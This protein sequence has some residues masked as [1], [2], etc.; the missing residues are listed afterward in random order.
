MN[1]SVLEHL[2]ADSWGWETEG[3]LQLFEIWCIAKQI[4]QETMQLAFSSPFVG[5]KLVQ[6]PGIS[7]IP[8]LQFLLKNEEFKYLFLTEVNRINFEAVEEAHFHS[9]TPKCD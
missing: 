1:S 7:L 9:M 8:E 4:A 2:E 3:H 6:S 5:K